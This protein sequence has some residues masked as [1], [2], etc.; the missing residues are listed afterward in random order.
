MR[1]EDWRDS[2]LRNSYSKKSLQRRPRE[3][4]RLLGGKQGVRRMESVITLSLKPPSV[5]SLS[6]PHSPC[7]T[8]LECPLQEYQSWALWIIYARVSQS[9]HY[10]HLGPNHHVVEGCPVHCRMFSCILCLYPLDASRAHPSSTNH[11]SWQ[12]KMTL[13][14]CFFFFG[15]PTWHVKPK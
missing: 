14:V 2:C 11:H 3:T 8:L 13:T 6:R 7:S 10:W 15:Y 9:W 1:T 4:A 5:T 12:A